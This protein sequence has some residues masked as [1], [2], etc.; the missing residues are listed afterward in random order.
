MVPRSYLFVPG[1]RP[2]RFAKALA[3]G[4]DAVVID[5]EDAVSPAAKDAAR[6]SLQEWFARLGPDTP[7][8][9]VVVRVNASDT[10]WFEEDLRA[11]AAPAVTAIMVPKAER[12]DDLGRIAALHGKPLIALVET[13]AGFDNLRSVACA[14]GV[15]RLA[16]GSI[17]FQLDT[18]ISGDGDELLL[19]RSQ[20]VLMSRIA[21][22]APPVDGVSTSIS[23]AQMVL[24]EAQRAR[25]LGFGAKLCIHPAQ[26]D[27]VNRSFNPSS[28]EIDWAQRVLAAATSAN[29][30]AFAVDGKMVDKPVVLRAEAILRQVDRTS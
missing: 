2:E 7:T 22:L 5:L 13:A 14:A 17:D 3:S 19:F 28:A 16:F 8:K 15:L 20:M 23:D 27:A 11:C 21:G 29:G 18:G 26:V 4:A 1:D 9:P 24:D 30:S 12:A 6:S 25:R 10:A